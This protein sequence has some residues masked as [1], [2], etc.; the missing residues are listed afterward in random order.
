MAKELNIA[1][2]FK[3]S[4]EPIKIQ[5]SFVSEHDSATSFDILFDS[6]KK[7]QITST[8]PRIGNTR[9]CRYCY[10]KKVGEK[11]TEVR[12]T[13]RKDFLNYQLDL[14]MNK[15][16]FLNE[17]DEMI[18]DNEEYFNSKDY[19]L[20]EDYRNLIKEI[21]GQISFEKTI[22]DSSNANST[23]V[24]NFPL[25]TEVSKRDFTY[26][27]FISHSS[28]D[29]QIAKRLIQVLKE[30]INIESSKILC[31]S[32]DGYKLEGGVNTDEQLRKLIE[33]NN[34]FIGIISENSIQ[35]HY[36]LFELGARWG[37]GLPIKP[38]VI[39]SEVYSLLREPIK[40]YNVLNLESQQEVIQLLQE[41]SKI[42]KKPLEN[43]AVYLNSIDDLIQDI[44][45]VTQP[46]NS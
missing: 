10:N 35:S 7:C 9:I 43:P 6:L 23:E 27:I 39:S 33:D 19:S 44:K 24:M 13:K 8:N 29:K 1:S 22:G 4:E 26:D 42:L 16:A 37:L 32:V 18:I 12:R 21:Q 3:F 15:E 11:M 5:D 25:N 28:S 20:V 31:T 34:V 41:I 14:R 2:D 38:V 45:R 30:A 17:L 40:N 46:N 36:V